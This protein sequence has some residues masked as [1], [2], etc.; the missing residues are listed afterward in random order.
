MKRKEPR[1]TKTV[2]KMNNVIGPRQRGDEQ[3]LTHRAGTAGSP[4]AESKCGPLLHSA[5]KEFTQ[6]DLRLK[7]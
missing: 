6:M 5:L 4:R 1:V 7:H 2:V 3:S